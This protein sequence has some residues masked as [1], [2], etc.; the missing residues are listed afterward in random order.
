M[1]DPGLA[2]SGFTVS[3]SAYSIRPIWGYDVLFT[4]RGHESNTNTTGH[5]WLVAAT[6]ALQGTGA[7]AALSA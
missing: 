4:G 1:S 3:E 7:A 5:G 2:A 6:R